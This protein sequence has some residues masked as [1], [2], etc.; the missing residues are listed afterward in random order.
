MPLRGRQ[1]EPYRAPRHDEG[2]FDEIL[3]ATCQEEQRRGIQGQD[4]NICRAGVV[5]ENTFRHRLAIKM[6]AVMRQASYGLA[7]RRRVPQVVQSWLVTTI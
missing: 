5:C 4:R 7:A 2:E 3:T 1:G 6:K